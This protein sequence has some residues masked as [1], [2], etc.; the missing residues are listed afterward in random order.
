MKSGA[1]IS[2]RR[3]CR[4]GR[5]AQG[6]CVHAVLRIHVDHCR[7]AVEPVSSSINDLNGCAA[8]NGTTA[9]TQVSTL[10]KTNRNDKTKTAHRMILV[11]RFY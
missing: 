9:W 11:R 3:F 8:H 10:R 4:V 5:A 2:G 6:T 7:E 1:A